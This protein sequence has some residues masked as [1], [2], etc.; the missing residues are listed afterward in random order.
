MGASIKV[1]GKMAIIEG[2]YA[3]SAAKVRAVDLRAGAAMVVAGLAT[4]GITEIEDIHHIERG[5]DN[6][7]GK[8]QAVGADIRK[9]YVPDEFSEKKAN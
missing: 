4:P 8:L 6:I 7:V 3:L 2:G 1:D 5:Y 9:I